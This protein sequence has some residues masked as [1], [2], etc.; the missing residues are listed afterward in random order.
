MRT[1]GKHL[2]IDTDADLTIHVHLGMPGRVRVSGAG[3]E[4]WEERGAVRLALTTSAGTVWV[5][6]APTVDVDRRAAIDR[7]LRR[8]GPDVLGDGLDRQDLESRASRYPPGRTI[9]D[10][11]LDQRVVSGIGNEYKCEALFLQGVS[12]LRTAGTVDHETRLALVERA[13]RIMKPN[14]HR[15]ERTTTGRRDAPRWVFERGGRPCRR[16]RTAIVSDWIGEPARITYWCP[17]CQ[18]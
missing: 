3:K 7:S 17:T 9:S 18:T 10:F 2:L 4:P 15:S 5:L 12:P 1:H 8:L 16:C 11:L 13:R 14:A 6:S